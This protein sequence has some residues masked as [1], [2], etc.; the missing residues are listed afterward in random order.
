LLHNFPSKEASMA[1]SG[2]RKT[3]DRRGNDDL[4][5]GTTDEDITG[6][7]DEE[8]DE[9]FEDVDDLEEEDEIDESDR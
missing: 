5:S 4:M 2:D 9:E 8:D 7:V 1:E 3:G 6:R